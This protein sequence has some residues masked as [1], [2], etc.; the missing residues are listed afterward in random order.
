MRT[1]NL[2][3]DMKCMLDDPDEDDPDEGEAPP[4]DVALAELEEPEDVGLDAIC[5]VRSSTNV[6]E[7]RCW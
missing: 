2:G 3:D 6:P 1:I 5:W 7:S 4:V